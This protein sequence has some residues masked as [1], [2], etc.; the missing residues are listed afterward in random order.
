MHGAGHRV[1]LNDFRFSFHD[2]PTSVPPR[3]LPPNPISSSYMT[4]H[5]KQQAEL[6]IEILPAGEGNP[7]NFMRGFE[8]QIS[9]GCSERR[10]D[11]RNDKV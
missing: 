3:L 4:I 1:L 7:E 2:P 9:L 5:C 11:L 8:A 6:R 10:D